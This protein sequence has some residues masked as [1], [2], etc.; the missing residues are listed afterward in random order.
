MVEEMFTIS[1]I[2]HLAMK[3]EKNGEAFY[4]EALQR[5]SDASI[6]SLFLWLAEEEVRHGDWFEKRKKALVGTPEDDV[7][8][9]MGRKILEDI[10][11]DQIFSLKETDLSEVDNVDAVIQ[12]AIEFEEDTILFFNMIKELVGDDETLVGLN[13]IIEEE[14]RHV[15]ML[16]ER[17]RG[18]GGEGGGLKEIR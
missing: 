17:K 3:V 15:Q 1:E 13:E 18:S 2:Y 5:A 4:R 11:G 10:L 6:Q 12:L 8:E 7:I 16:G 9:E 14:N